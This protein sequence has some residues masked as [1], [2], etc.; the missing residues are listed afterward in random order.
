MPTNI[1]SAY[2]ETVHSNDV[3][4][5]KKKFIERNVLH[6]QRRLERVGVSAL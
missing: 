4:Y 2:P 1:L 3:N 5:D 6:F